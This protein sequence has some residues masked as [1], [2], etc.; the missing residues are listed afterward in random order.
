M[1][2]SHSLLG[3]SPRYG[4]CGIHQKFPCRKF[5]VEVGGIEP[6]SLSNRIEAATCLAPHFKLTLATPAGQDLQIAAF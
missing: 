1:V 2:A 4:R 6:P 3:L 5:L